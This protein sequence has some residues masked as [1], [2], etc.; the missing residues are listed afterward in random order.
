MNPNIGFTLHPNVRASSQVFSGLRSESSSRQTKEDGG[1]VP[2][3][4]LCRK[5]ARRATCHVTGLMSFSTK[6]GLCELRDSSHLNWGGIMGKAITYAVAVCIISPSVHAQEAPVQVPITATENRQ[7]DTGAKAAGVLEDLQGAVV[8]SGATAATVQVDTKQMAQ[9]TGLSCPKDKTGLTDGYDMFAYSLDRKAATELQLYG[10]A[11]LNA[12]DRVVLYQWMWYKD[13]QDAAGKPT[14]RCGSGISLALKVK[15]FS[16]SMSTSLPFLAAS[17][18]LD[19]TEIEYRL[20]TFGISGT[21][22]NSAFPSASRLGEFN[23][24]SYA[25]LLSSIDKVQAAGN[26]A[27]GVTFTPKIVSVATDSPF[28]DMSHQ[29][30]AYAYSLMQISRG[31]KCSA[32]KSSLAGAD[33]SA[34]ALV[35][36][37]YRGFFGKDACKQ[38]IV[39]DTSIRQR[40]SL[41]MSAHHMKWQN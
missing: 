17:A 36:D 18:Q 35:E 20:Y 8:G 33:S 10:A 40:A 5:P 24:Q 19:Q 29:A 7:V 31:Q 41:L 6:A 9:T 14:A 30:A 37:F 4:I 12:G 2:L 22:I 23:A 39:P 25:E 28:I 15:N 16:G 1:L 38:D 34:G 32:A 27:G 13:I 21:A 26:A 3:S 11:S